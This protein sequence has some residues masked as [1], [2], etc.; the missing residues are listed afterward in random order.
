MTEL[1]TLKDIEDYYCRADGEFDFIRTEA[2]KWCKECPHR[3]FTWEH[4]DTFPLK[5][6]TC[7]MMVE[8]FNLTDE[9][10]K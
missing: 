9:D 4:L 2:I 7:L 8:F 6:S 10:L 3:K 5:C 1:K